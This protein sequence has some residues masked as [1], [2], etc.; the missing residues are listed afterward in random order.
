MK[1]SLIH[2]DKRGSILSL[3]SDIL[4][5]DEVTVFITNAGFAR[6]GCVHNI[7]DEHCCVIN[8]EVEYTIGDETMILKDGDSVL[9][10]KGTPRT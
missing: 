9:I 8:G 10:P 3:K 6:G 2:Q 4:S 1:L 7:N 5:C